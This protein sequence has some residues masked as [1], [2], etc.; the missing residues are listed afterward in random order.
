MSN[1]IGWPRHK[2][3]ARKQQSWRLWT[4]RQRRLERRRQSRKGMR[5]EPD[6][7]P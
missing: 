5:Y 6:P 3:K 7:A 2:S 1:R 4:T